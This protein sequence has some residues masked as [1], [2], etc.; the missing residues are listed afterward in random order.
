MSKNY[1][2]GMPYSAMFRELDSSNRWGCNDQPT[3]DYVMSI[4]KEL[5]VTGLEMQDD[6]TLIVTFARPL[7]QRECFKF[8]RMN[9]DEPDEVDAFQV[10]FRLWWD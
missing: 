4:L 6:A 2:V 1:F 10:V 3:L 9:F 5:P 8:A 7:N